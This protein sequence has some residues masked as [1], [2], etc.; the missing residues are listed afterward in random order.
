MHQIRIFQG[1][2]YDKES[3]HIFWWAIKLAFEKTGQWSALENHTTYS[4][5]G[6]SNFLITIRLSDIFS[7]TDQVNPARDPIL[8]IKLSNRRPKVHQSTFCY[9]PPERKSNMYE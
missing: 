5:A 8:V 1:Y 7:K 3:K 9:D 4:S 2:Q 6:K